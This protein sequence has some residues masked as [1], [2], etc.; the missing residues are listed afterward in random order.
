MEPG[1]AVAYL[2]L[3]WLIGAT[4]A[5]A[6]S[7]RRGRALAAALAERHPERYEALGRPQ[8]GWFESA[9]RTRFAQF[10]MRREYENLGDPELSARFDDYRGAELRLLV[11]VLG[12]MVVVAAL[13]I[14]VS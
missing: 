11:A 1:K 2:A 10:V 5:M 13:G 6:R 4:I 8:P 3:G 7:I 14:A 9:R 12:T